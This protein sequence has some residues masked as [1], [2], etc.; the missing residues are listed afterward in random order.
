MKMMP[1]SPSNLKLYSDCPRKYKACYIEKLYR[2][3]GNQYTRRGEELHKCM[4][5]EVTA[6]KTGVNPPKWPAGEERARDYGRKVLSHLDIAGLVKQG[7]DVSSEREQ[8]VSRLGT[9]VPWW[10]DMAY[11]RSRVD[12]LLVAP[13]RSEG[14]V[15]DWKS[16]KTRGTATQLAI[17]V[18]TLPPEFRD[19]GEFTGVFVYLDQEEA[20][21]EE[22]GR[23][24][25]FPLR[26]DAAPPAFGPALW[27]CG[28]LERSWDNDRFPKKP[29]DACR[30]CEIKAVCDGETAGG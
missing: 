26:L 14:L 11:M 29:G 8:A 30:W 10:D 5:L 21:A 6:L 22:M 2:F 4:E 13:D 24:P 17:N 1:I 7:W 25:S 27:A 9:M 18:L 28:W 3:E 20:E 15:I 19:E 12:L 23:A 16:G